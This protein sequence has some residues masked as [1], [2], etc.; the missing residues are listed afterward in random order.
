VFCRSFAASLFVLLAL[1][2]CGGS[3]EAPAPAAGPQ[4]AVLV[5]QDCGQEVVVERTE[6]AA[7][8]T[9]MRALKRVADVETD[10]G[11]KF[12]TAIEG[13]EQDEGKQ[14]AWLFYVDGA[15]AEKGATEIE[16]EAGAVEWWDL[17]DWNEECQVPAAAQ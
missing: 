11:G 3:N 17:H 15:V 6:V 16:L 5:T 7:G 2:A 1:A 8:Q 12:V 4:A 9:A 14:L 10:D 13:I